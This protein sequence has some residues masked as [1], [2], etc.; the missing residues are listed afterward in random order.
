MDEVVTCGVG[1]LVLG[2]DLRR[3]VPHRHCELAHTAVILLMVY[4]VQR[5]DERDT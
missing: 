1:D 3:H 2:H 5:T 4:R